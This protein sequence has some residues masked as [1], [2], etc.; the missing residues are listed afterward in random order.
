MLL[1]LAALIV[2][3]AL[4]S[5]IAARES[6]RPTPARLSVVLSLVFWFGVG[7]AGRAIGFVSSSSGRV[8]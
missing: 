4:F 2:Q 1:L 5:R 6:A 8:P 3:F 7:I